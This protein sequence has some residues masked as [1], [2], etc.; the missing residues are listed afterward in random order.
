MPFEELIRVADI[1][2]IHVPLTPS[3]ANLFD[4][5]VIK[6]VKPGAIIVNTSRGGI[7]D[8]DALVK[9]LDSGFVGGAVLDVFRDEPNVPIEL[10]QMKNV[11]LTPHIAG[12]TRYARE[13]C[14]KRA[15]ENVRAALK[16]EKPVNAL[17]QL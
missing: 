3:T 6:K 9:A 1:I 13:A 12:G 10:L 16:N 7:V 11:I 5:E 14:V 4:H 2:S 8:Q 17:N 15:V